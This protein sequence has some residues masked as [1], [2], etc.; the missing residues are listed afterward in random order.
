MAPS[1]IPGA[2]FGV[3]TTKKIRSG[4]AIVNYPAAPSIPVVDDY[5]HHKKDPVNAHENYYWNSDGYTGFEGNEVHEF[6]VNFGS[7]CNYHSYLAN[8]GHI[9]AGY[10]DSLADRFKDPTTGSFSNY[11]GQVFFA[12]RNLKPGE[13]IFADYGSD[14]LD[15]REGYSADAVPREVDFETAASIV[16]QLREAW[17]A[18]GGIKDLEYDIFDMVKSISSLMSERV[19]NLLPQT[20]IELE[21]LTESMKNEDIE[22]KLALST[23]VQRD[24][25]WIEQYGIC[26]DNIVNKESTIPTA[27]HGAFAARQI[28]AGSVIIPAP[29]LQVADRSSLNIYKTV[30]DE[31]SGGLKHDGSEVVGHQLMMNYCFGD[32][33]TSLLLCPSTNA[34]LM[35]HCSHRKFG[36]GQC[37]NKGPN[38]EIRWASWDPYIE[39]W[40]NST[41][42][43]ISK[44]T[45]NEQRGLSF[46]FVAIRDI[47]ANEEIFIDYGIEW[48]EA[49]ESHLQSWEA[50]ADDSE[51]ASHVSISKM[52]M[53]KDFRTEAELKDKP[54]EDNIMTACFKITDEYDED[55]ED[56]DEDEDYEGYDDSD[57]VQMDMNDP[58]QLITPGRHHILT[59]GTSSSGW[60]RP[61]K[62]LAKGKNSRG[63]TSYAVRILA[64]D[65]GADETVGWISKRKARIITDFPQHSILFVTKKYKSDQLLPN[66]FRHHIGMRKDMI[67]DKWKNLKRS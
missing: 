17:D 31:Y 10:D 57:D 23:T 67:P 30:T 65:S 9:Q 39:Q 54:Y 29:L 13:E 50:P 12:N 62:I 24:V 15:T 16:K 56:E 1:S 43:E 20:G 41:V 40:L 47:D 8:V 36:G 33:S 14:W 46:D 52:N 48:E 28:K 60:Y 3:F 5:F 63:A 27:G 55:D 37:G 25:E 66:T 44:M 49:F 7:L 19:A 53:K 18:S 64:S 45:M 2:G 26:I 21:E 6:V 4:A 32:S 51:F 35:N 58:G 34:L 38:A 22:M 11:N 61:C 42:K 59:P